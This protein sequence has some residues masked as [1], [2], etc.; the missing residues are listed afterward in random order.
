MSI[1][2][3]RQR[4][5]IVAG[6]ASG[7]LLGAGLIEALRQ[8]W[9]HAEFAGIGGDRMR[10]AG[11]EAWHDA[12]ELAV[13]GLAEVLRHLPRLLRLRRALR[14]RVLAWRPDVFI[15]IDAPDFNLGV[16]RW[17]K[18]RGIATVHYVS[19][20]VWAWREARAAKIGRSADRVLCLFPME[21]AIYAKH[22]VDAR[23]VGHPL[24]DTMALEPDRTAARGALGLPLDA[25]VLALLPGSRTGEIE[26]LGADF[27]DAASRVLAQLPTLRIVA[28]MADRRA[29]ETFERVLAQSP[30][31]TALGDAL[32][33]IDGQAR[34]LMVASDVILLASGTATLEGM[35]AKR[36]MVVAYK[37]AA[38][39]YR[40]VKGLGMLKVDRYALPNILAGADVVPELMQDDCTPAGLAAAVL[41]WF[42]D[43]DA[44]AALG[45]RFMNLHRELR[46][47]ASSRAADAIVEV[48]SSRHG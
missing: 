21:P 33:I 44:A 15:G 41:Q 32:S 47:D 42:G 12:G 13:M 23:F 35:L 16:E 28:P 9:P 20:S 31:R 37:V 34:T 48:V 30:A 10:D 26:R 18:Q 27:L 29:R 2:P 45:P 39:T 22:G 6:E 3:R 11:F 43:A 46:R 4:I 7:D 19:P 36:P 24:A 38:S 14:E 5:A 40:L 17:L 8:R 1:E 25:P